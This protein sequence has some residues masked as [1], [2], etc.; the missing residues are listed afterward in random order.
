MQLLDRFSER[1][2]AFAED[3]RQF[4]SFPLARPRIF[5]DVLPRC[6][7]GA[8]KH[9]GVPADTDRNHI[10]SEAIEAEHIGYNRDQAWKSTLSATCHLPM[11]VRPNPTE[12]AAGTTAYQGKHQGPP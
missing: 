9:S 3:A 5:A 11:L 4:F 10:E 2:E 8:G 6:R 12:L 7:P 1:S